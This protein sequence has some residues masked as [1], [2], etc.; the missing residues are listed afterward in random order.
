VLQL[1]RATGCPWDEET[2]LAAAGEGHL[3]IVNWLRAN[4]YPWDMDT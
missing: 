2:C 3:E 1:L 4:G